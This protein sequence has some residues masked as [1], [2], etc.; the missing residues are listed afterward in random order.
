MKSMYLHILGDTLGSVSLLVSTLLIRFADGGAERWAWADA[1][2]SLGIAV[3]MLGSVVP[4]M[5]RCAVIL[6]SVYQS[7]SQS[8]YN[9]SVYQWLVGSSMEHQHE[10]A[11]HHCVSRIMMITLPATDGSTIGNAVLAVNDLVCY[12][13]ADG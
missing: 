2:C 6:C 13:V 9:S 8:R 11:M 5:C 1:L 4:L 10:D 7:T 3:V 12:E